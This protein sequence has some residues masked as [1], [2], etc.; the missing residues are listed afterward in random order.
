M[1]LLF[2]IFRLILFVEEHLFHFKFLA[3]LLLRQALYLTLSWGSWDFGDGN[4]ETAIRN[5]QHIYETPGT[6]DVSSFCYVHQI[7]VY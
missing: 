3:T 6:Y 4:I 7:N 2:Q 1:H 5:P